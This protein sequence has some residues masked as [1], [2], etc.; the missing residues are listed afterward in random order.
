MSGSGDGEFQAT[1]AAQQAQMQ[2]AHAQ[3]Q[4]I[5]QREEQQ[6][7]ADRERTRAQRLLMRT[8]RASGGGFFETDPQTLGG[9]GALG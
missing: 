3:Q 8:L 9:T 1:V 4:L 7:L 5:R 2:A 6:R